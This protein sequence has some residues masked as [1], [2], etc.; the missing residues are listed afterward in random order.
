[1]DAVVE[2]LEEMLQKRNINP[3]SMRILVLKK[4]LKTEVALSLNDLDSQLDQ[5]DRST[6]FRTLKTFEEHKL[7][8]AIEDGTGAV[9]Y[10]LCES[11]CLCTPEFAH[12]H[13][14]C[15]ICQNTFC[16]RKVHL[17]EIVLPKNFEVEQ[18]SIVLRGVC[19][20]CT[21]KSRLQ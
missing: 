10:A 13:F 20:H 14:H 9:K 8:H 19:D 3:T 12:A 6:I 18:S 2:N 21:P 5:A 16:L 11:N 7:I 1:M 17:P 4:L 15:T